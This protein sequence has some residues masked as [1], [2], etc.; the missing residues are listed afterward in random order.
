MNILPAKI[1][2]CLSD[3]SEYI[4][5]YA[6]LVTFD[7]LCRVETALSSDGVMTPVLTALSDIT[8]E[9]IEFIYPIKDMSNDTYYYHSL[10][11]TNDVTTINKLTPDTDE[12]MKDVIIVKDKEQ[13]RTLSVGMLTAHRFYVILT[14]TRTQVAVNLDLE[15]KIIAAGQSLTLESFTA[16]DREEYTFLERYADLVAKLNHARPLRDIPIGWCSWSC[17]YGEVNE[18]KINRVIDNMSG[19]EGANLVQIDDGWQKNSSFCGDW[20]YDENKFPN[21][22]MPLAERANQNG[23]TFGLWLSPLIIREAS[24]HYESLKHM[25][26]TDVCTLDATHPFD[27]DNEDFYAHLTKTFKRMTEEYGAKYFKLDFLMCS[28]KRFVGDTTMVRYESDYRCALFRKALMT[29]REAVGDDAILLSCGAPILECAGIFDA[30]RISCD[31][32]WGKNKDFPSYWQIMQNTT[33]TALYRQFYNKKVFRNDPD[34][35]VMRDFDRGDGFDCKYAEARLWATT[36]ALAGGLVLLNEEYEKLSPDRKRLFTSLIPPVNIS[37]KAVDMFEY[38]QPT[39]AYLTLD[40]NT[41]YL[42][43]YNYSDKLE[44]MEFDLARLGLERSV[45]IDCWEGRVQSVGTVVKTKDMMPHSASMFCIVKMPEKP[46]FLYSNVNIYLGRGHFEST[47]EDGEVKITPDA[48]ISK[49]IT[50]STSTYAVYPDGNELPTG[51]R[52]TFG[53]DGITVVKI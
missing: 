31:I 36:V 50:E 52:V 11:Q 38:P 49:Y 32:I 12:L 13:N 35:L 48:E 19:I 8:P 51:A 41:T 28:I 45:I 46:E 25:V 18:E 9:S 16:D 37:G 7:G 4:K 6:D 2:L 15:G 39:S 10:I 47:L 44:D 40:E 42:A 53:G 22:L 21:G 26:R 3:G 29:I 33:K 27:L 30:Q 34:G 17:Y 43:L 5:N 24:G 1:R 23:L 14:I 20:F